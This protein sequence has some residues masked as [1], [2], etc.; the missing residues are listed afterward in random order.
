MYLGWLRN[1]AWDVDW[2]PVHV[3]ITMQHSRTGHLQWPLF[4]TSPEPGA[5]HSSRDI[6][7]LPSLRGSTK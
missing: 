1:T 2:Q 4:E 3:H 6:S 7:R 5:P